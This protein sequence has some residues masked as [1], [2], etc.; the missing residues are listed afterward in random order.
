MAV[1]EALLLLERDGRARGAVQRAQVRAALAAY[2]AAAD[3]DVEGAL[4][5]ATRP[6]PHGEAARAVWELGPIA[7]ARDLILRFAEEE[8]RLDPDYDYDVDVAE[9]SEEEGRWCAPDAAPCRPAVMAAAAAAAPGL[10]PLPVARV[11]PA[12]RH[13]AGTWHWSAPSTG[14]ARGGQQSAAAATAQPLAAWAL[15]AVGASVFVPAAPAVLEAAPVPPGSS[16]SASGTLEAALAAPGPRAVAEA[17]PPEAC[18]AA[19]AAPGPQAEAAMAAAVPPVAPA[20]PSPAPAVLTEAVV[21]EG[22]AA[23]S[24]QAPGPRAPPLLAVVAVPP[25]SWPAPAAANPAEERRG[26][27]TALGGRPPG[28]GAAPR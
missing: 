1:H 21:E 15:A 13:S 16:P 20:A 14:V 25:R 17:L 2:D 11:P 27:R 22:A 12:P 6:P 8:G 10:Q 7:A 4:A 9:E 18:M 24:A 3:G 19:G 23:L 5:W 28:L 26:W